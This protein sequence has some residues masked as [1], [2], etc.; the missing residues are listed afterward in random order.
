MSFLA[1]IRFPRPRLA[2]RHTSEPGRRWVRRVLFVGSVVLVAPTVMMSEAVGQAH[3]TRGGTVGI[4]SDTE[5]ELFFGLICMCGCPRET[6]GTCAC[7]YGGERRAELRAM[8]AQGMD[9]PAIQKAYSD[10]FGTHAVALPPNSGASRLIW[11]APLVALIAGAFGIVRLM[12]KWSAKGTRD[13]AT[14]DKATADKAKINGP[15]KRDA[16]DE[17]LDDELKELDRE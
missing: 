13:A 5:R 4:Q 9:I 7:E 3:V 6:L 2:G 8:L 10:R 1:R 15:A 11:A 14:A 12:R 16:Y 17:R